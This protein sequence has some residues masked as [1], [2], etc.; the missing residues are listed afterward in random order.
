[1]FIE[2]LWLLYITFIAVC[3]H[4]FIC[5]SVDAYGKDRA[6]LLMDVSST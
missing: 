2:L 1:M 5:V 4:S 6:Y 3:N